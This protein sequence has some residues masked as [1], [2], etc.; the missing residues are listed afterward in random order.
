MLKVM[1]IGRVGCG[2]TTLKQ[3]INNQN[4]KYEKTQTI[5]FDDGVIDTPGEYL[6]NRMYL[7]ALLVT[8]NDADV[9][10]LLEDATKEDEVYSYGF[11]SAFTKEVIGIVTKVDE[12]SEKQIAR[13]HNH[14][15]NAGASIIYNIGFNDEDQLKEFLTRLQGGV[16]E[17]ESKSS[18]SR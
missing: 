2:K 14:L 8:A 4:I 3:R 11:K 12:A 1:L 16:Y 10:V 5:Q 6:E 7:H 18:N 15:K 9:I 17:N 13:A